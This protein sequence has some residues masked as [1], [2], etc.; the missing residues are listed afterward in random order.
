MQKPASQFLKSSRQFKISNH[1]CHLARLISKVSGTDSKP[2]HVPSCCVIHCKHGLIVQAT[3][4]TQISMGQVT[5]G[6]SR[7]LP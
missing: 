5:T 2:E 7:T 6:A 4:L 1:V 3:Y